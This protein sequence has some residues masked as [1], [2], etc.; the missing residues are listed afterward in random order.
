[1]AT[2]VTSAWCLFVRNFHTVTAVIK[3]Y[4][5]VT[6]SLKLTCGRCTAGCAVRLAW[7]CWHRVIGGTCLA[8]GGG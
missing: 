7:W 1:M 6:F 5:E 4:Q 2:G 3:S 8:G